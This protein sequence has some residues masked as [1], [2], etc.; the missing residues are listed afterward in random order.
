MSE[1]ELQVFVQQFKHAPKLKKVILFN[2]ETAPTDHSFW[3]NPEFI[4]HLFDGYPWHR[5]LELDL[6]AARRHFHPQN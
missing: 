6:P 1:A 2:N 5:A 4:D 3:S